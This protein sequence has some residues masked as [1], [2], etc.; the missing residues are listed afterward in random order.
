MRH[1]SAQGHLAMSLLL[2]RLGVAVVMAF[3]TA[4]KI[5]NPDHA[6]AVFETSTALVASEAQPSRLSG[7][8][9]RCS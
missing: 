6:G 1:D 3:W 4:D 5:V 8:S 2:L 9:K 7:S